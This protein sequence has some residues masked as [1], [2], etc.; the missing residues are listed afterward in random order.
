[1]AYFNHAFKKSFL[2][3]GPTQTAFPVTLPNGTTVNA[4]TSNG[5]LTS[6]GVPTY[7]LNQLSAISVNTYGTAT[8]ATTDGYIG[9]FNPKT[10][11][12]VDIND[13][14]FA[15]CCNLY[16]AGSAIYSNDKIGPLTGGYQETNKSKMVNPKYVSRFYQVDPC[17]PQNN[18]IHVGST[19]WTA[20]GGVLTG[21]ITT[22]GV[23]YAPN[24]ATAAAVGTTTVTGTGTGL[25]VKIT[26]AA[27][28]PSLPIAP[29]VS[30]VN[31]GKGYAVGDTVT[32]NSPSGTPGTLAVY[33][34]GTVT[35]SHAQEGCG[36][37]PECCKEFLCGET[38]SLR[39]DVK[40]SPALRFLNHN[41]Y[42]T[43]DAYTGCCDPTSIA[44]TP[45][46]STNVMILWANGL[47]TNPIVGPFVQI[48]VQAENGQLLYAPGTSATFLAANR[49]IT[50][51]NYVSPGHVDGEC[52]GL[53]LNGA[54]VDTKFG[55]CTFQLSDFYEKEPVRLYASEVD[56]NGDPCLFTT[57]CVVTQCQGL[58]VNGLGE[59]V[60]RDMT[61]SESY[62]QNFLA[63]DFRI[64]EITQGNQIISSVD[65]SALYY[66]Y[67]L[68]HN[69]PRNYN[70]SGTFDADQYMLEIFSLVPL[71]TF[72]TDTS[73]WLNACGVCEIN[74]LED[75][76]GCDTVCNVPIAFPA[77]P[78]YNP[79]NTVA[80][81]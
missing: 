57:L 75:A 17:E 31:P 1:M 66:R 59:T 36:I 52:A 72:A 23:G 4:T 42:Y 8:T 15:P 70:P 47:T 7:G 35:A 54:Y 79:Y 33:T 9:W 19:Y 48:V 13:E 5:Y 77:I 67:M 22:P 2:A 14:G 11:L 25:E 73:G 21:S 24:S 26:I 55:D 81:N 46:D 29:L 58:Q 16:L 40:G 76:Y 60:V 38:Y 49:A 27:G 65:R 6:N 30:I 41:A 78:V 12:S 71:N 51:D 64:R 43:V 61:L 80:C 10:N 68:Q 69:V 63:T 37:T 32:I 34:I 53:I 62:R 20:G 3:T 18:V 74:V 44:P 56:L 45:V 50:W 28:V 39:L